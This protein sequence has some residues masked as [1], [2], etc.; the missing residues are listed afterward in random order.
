MNLAALS[1]SMIAAGLACEHL[2]GESGTLLVMPF[3]GRVMGLFAPGSAENFLWVNDAF[4]SSAAITA[5]MNA[6]SWMNSGGDRTWLAPEA[7]HFFPEFPSDQRFVPPVEFEP[8][9][10]R[11]I[12][13]GGA[14]CCTLQDEFST[15]GV[16]SG[17]VNRVR[18]TK[19]FS[20]IENPIADPTIGHAAEYAGY[21]ATTTLVLQNRIAESY[22]INIW[23]LLQLPHGGTMLVPTVERTAPTT[24]FGEVPGDAIEVSDKMVRY[25]MDA[26]GAQ[27]IG[28]S[29]ESCVGRA[30]Y[31]YVA[32]D[33]EALIV[34][35]FQID[36]AGA[37]L[38]APMSALDDHGYA[39]QACN[40]SNASQGS[41]VELEYHVPAIGGWTGRTESID[42]SEVWAY[43]GPSQV[44]DE[45]EQIL[46]SEDSS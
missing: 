31:R 5:L 13:E 9:A 38:D 42:V 12:A 23:S 43:R 17:S 11:R 20:L 30:G 34:R 24:F 3:G 33:E 21:R 19:S 6:E 25:R 45:V 7:D 16:R 8:G 36:P 29:A 18:L 35:Q 41:Y 40:I 22:P 37:Y 4:A 44:I 27:K 32:G 2:E 46:L 39:F 1:Q 15:T 26:T 10:Y 14:G 28:L